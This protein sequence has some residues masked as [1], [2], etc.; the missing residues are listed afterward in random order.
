MSPSKHIDISI[1]KYPVIKSSAFLF[2]SVCL[3]YISLMYVS[4]TLIFT[5]QFYYR[6]YSDFASV[7]IIEAFIEIKNRFSWAGYLLHPFLIF[8]K[9]LFVTCCICTGAILADINFQFASIFQSSILAEC[10]FIIAQIVNV[11]NLF[12]HKEFVT[13]ETMAN[14][15]PLSALSF[16]GIENVVPWLHYLL[17][18][19]NFFE[20]FYILF[21]SWLLSKQWKPGLTD[22]LNIV[23]PSYGTGLLLWVLLVTFLRLHIG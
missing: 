18:T 19:L 16:Y 17:Q 8:I 15:F 10:V 12:Y 20:V 14:Y 11:I 13:I 21:I 6:S 22:T 3:I 2:I 1:S 23:L 7:N 9:L 4:T 5:D